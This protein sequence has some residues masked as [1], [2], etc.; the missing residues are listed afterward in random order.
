MTL[1]RACW[2]WLRER[3]RWVAGAVF[4]LLLLVV[5]LWARRPRPSPRRRKLAEKHADVA[6]AAAGVAAERVGV[7]V[8]DIA[9]LEAELDAATGAPISSP[10]VAAELPERGPVPAP[11]RATMATFREPDWDEDP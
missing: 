7:A 3:W 1:L 10:I 8:S 2:R 9:E 11:W 5:G 6:A 4:G